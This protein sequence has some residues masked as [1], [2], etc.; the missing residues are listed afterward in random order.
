MSKSV[1]FE[2]SRDDLERIDKNDLNKKEQTYTQILSKKSQSH[3][4]TNIKLTKFV[5]LKKN[6]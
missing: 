5:N 2:L 4:I 3:Q 1:F 6:K